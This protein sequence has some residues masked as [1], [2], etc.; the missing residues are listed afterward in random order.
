MLESKRPFEKYLRE[1][2]KC[3]SEVIDETYSYSEKSVK[4]LLGLIDDWI[5]LVPKEKNH[6]FEATNSVSYTHL[7]LPTTER[8]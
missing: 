7:T 2:V 3:L 1:Y 5:D 8:V 4:M 6:F